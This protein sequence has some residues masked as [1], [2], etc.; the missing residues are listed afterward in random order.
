M[1]LSQALP[2]WVTSLPLVVVEDLLDAN[3]S[4]ARAAVANESEPPQGLLN[5]TLRETDRSCD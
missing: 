3:L 1:K 5:R 4:S 2:Q